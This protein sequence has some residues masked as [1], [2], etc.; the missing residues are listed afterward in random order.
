MYT[1]EERAK[2]RQLVARW[3]AGEKVFDA[4]KRIEKAD[5]T[6]VQR[7]EP[8]Q[9]IKRNFIAEAQR[10]HA[11]E[12]VG[13][14]MR[15]S[16]QRKQ[17]QAAKQY[18][19]QQYQKAKDDAKRAEG[20]E[21]M[22]KTVSPSTYVEAATGQDLG[23]TGRLITDAAAFG[24]PGAVKSLGNM[25]IRKAA[26][27]LI[28]ASMKRGL[29]KSP[30]IRTYNSSPEYLDAGGNILN[31]QDF[32]QSLFPNSKVKDIVYHSTWAKPFE[33]F[34]PTKI[35]RGYGFYFSPAE[36]HLPFDR[37]VYSRVNLKNPLE[38]FPNKNSNLDVSGLWRKQATEQA[39]KEGNHDGII[40]VSN[41]NNPG[42]PEIVA[43]DPNQIHILGSN[44]DKHMFKYFMEDNGINSWATINKPIKYIRKP[45]TASWDDFIKNPKLGNYIDAGGE[46]RIYESFNN[47]N[48]VTKVKS[49]LDN[50]ET[51]GDL[52]SVVNR[53]LH[54]NDLPGTEPVIYKGFTGETSSWKTLNRDT[55]KPIFHRQDQFYP[56]FEQRKLIPMHKVNFDA[57]NVDVESMINEWMYSNGYRYLQDGTFKYGNIIV[58]DNALHNFALD[59]FGN[60]KFIDPMIRKF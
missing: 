22:M 53:D 25:T 35:K 20:I 51:L 45:Y 33:Q 12:I 23:T 43:L 55:G 18:A 54:I 56:I 26:P 19:N 11:A 5:A 8:V 13:P 38:I 32:V 50:S 49:E 58:S 24:L 9:P 14:D 2:W 41:V 7:Q 48:Y 27:M 6:T 28:S 31:Y 21:Q 15:S 34:D 1:E 37:M 60:M 39:I 16:Y 40:G 47:P 10:K 4:G 3:K 30:T 46:A 42:E 57:F 36:R 29:S 17:S 44:K 52:E 59:G